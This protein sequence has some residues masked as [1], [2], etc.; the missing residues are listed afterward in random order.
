MQSEDIAAIKE[1][2]TTQFRSLACSRPLKAMRAWPQP[3][4]ESKEG[5]ASG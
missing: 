3:G 1:L 4:R 2:V 5:A